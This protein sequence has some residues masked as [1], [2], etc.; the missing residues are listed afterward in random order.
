MT[1][2]T[3]QQQD[4]DSGPPK[5][6]HLSIDFVRGVDGNVHTP[7]VSVY[8]D[9]RTV[10]GPIDAWDQRLEMT[11]GGRPGRTRSGSPATR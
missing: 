9:V 1:Y 4:V 8:G 10:Y 5:L 2:P 6:R 7:E 3:P 11:A